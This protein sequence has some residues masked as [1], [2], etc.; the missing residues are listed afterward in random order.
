VFL[1]GTAAE[2]IAVIKV[3]GR[4]IGDGTPGAITKELLVKFRERVVTEGVKVYSKEA[5][6]HVS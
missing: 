1:T 3:D 5:T 2:V 6:P 4:V